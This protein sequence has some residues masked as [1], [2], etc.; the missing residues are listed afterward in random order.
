MGRILGKLLEGLDDVL[1]YV[2]HLGAWGVG[3]WVC[4]GV[5]YAYRFERV[6]GRVNVGGWRMIYW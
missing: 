4:D 1:V 2:G 6:S 5:L 3:L